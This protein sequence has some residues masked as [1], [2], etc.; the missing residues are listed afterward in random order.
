M[1]RRAREPYAR[2]LPDGTPVG[3][4]QHCDKQTYIDRKSA[5]QG[6]RAARRGGRRTG[7]G[8]SAYECPHGA[9]WHLGHLRDHEHGR[10]RLRAQQG[11][12]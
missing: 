4:C 10:D 3:H 9:G 1:T 2:Y 6:R 11:G 12:S 8:L 7:T 5:R